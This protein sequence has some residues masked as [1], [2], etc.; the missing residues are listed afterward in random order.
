M[1]QQIKSFVVT[2]SV[3]RTLENVFFRVT[4]GFLCTALV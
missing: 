2:R 4:S 1:P 3:G